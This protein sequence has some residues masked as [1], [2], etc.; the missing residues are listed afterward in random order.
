MRKIEKINYI[1]Y[2]IMIFTGILFIATVGILYVPHI[3]ENGLHEF[4][5]TFLSNIFVG[6]VFMIGG[7]YGLACK[8]NLP[9]PLYMNF[10]IVLQ[11]VFCI[12][13]AFVDEFNFSGLFIFLHIFN[14]VLATIELFL[15]TDCDKKPS[16]RVIFSSLILPFIYLAY[17][18]IYGYKS[19]F[20]IYGIV[21]IPERGIKFVLLLVVLAATGILVLTWVQYT[22][23]YFITTG[24]KRKAYKSKAINCV[25]DTAMPTLLQWFKDSGSDLDLYCEKY[26]E[27]EFSYASVIEKGHIYEMGYPRCVC[28]EALAGVQDPNFCECSR[29]SMIF[30][31]KNMLP[32]KEIKV[33][34]IGT[35]LSGANRCSFK[36]TVK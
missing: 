32:D 9:Q 10:I 3:I 22:I 15:L 11:L 28:P 7:I 6:L 26:G 4:E 21:N 31:L 27:T 5:L 24:K 23:C 25:K 2:I 18:I 20:W 12:C 30:V 29:Q 36:V 33:E 35:V 16:D 8:K 1:K 19:G 14:P 34:T 17:V 13:M